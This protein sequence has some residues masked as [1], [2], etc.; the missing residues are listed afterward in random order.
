[1]RSIVVAFALSCIVITPIP[2]GAAS[3]IHL[4]TPQTRASAQVDDRLAAAADAARELS[5]LEADRDFDG[6][7]ERLH[8]DALAVV[9]RSAV[10]GWYE[11]YFEER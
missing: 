11:S 6:L 2:A 9:P 3:S 1:M 8:P 4:A 5:I 7:Y 10:V